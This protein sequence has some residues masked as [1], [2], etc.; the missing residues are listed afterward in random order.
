[1]DMLYRGSNGCYYT[2][3]Q[4][5]YYYETGA[6]KYDQRASEPGK[7]VVETRTGNTVAIVS[8]DT[9]SFPFSLPGREFKN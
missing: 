9:E 5:W 7:E 1:M 3:G 6:W 4:I 8:V 2:A